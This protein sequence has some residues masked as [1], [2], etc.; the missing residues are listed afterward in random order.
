MGGGNV[1]VQK[2]MWQTHKTGGEEDVPNSMD[3]G[4]NGWHSPLRGKKDGR[5]GKK[6][7]PSGGRMKNHE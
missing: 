3:E 1:R 5:Y 7:L 4:G 2:E 6:E